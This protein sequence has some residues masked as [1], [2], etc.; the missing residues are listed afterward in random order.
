MAEIK[1][2]KLV[3][4]VASYNVEA[5]QE[6]LANTD[7]LAEGIAETGADIVGL[8][9]I[10]MFLKRSGYKNMA[11]E[12]ARVAGYPHYRFV[13]AIDHQG[14]Q[15]GTAIL[16]KYP[17]EKMEVTNLESTNEKRSLGRFVINVEGERI[18]YL[19]THI[20]YL[21]P[22]IYSHID[23]LAKILEGYE[24]YV[25]TGDFNTCNFKLLEVFHGHRM[26]NNAENEL[27]SFPA[28]KAG[29]DNII[30][31]EDFEYSDPCL[32][33]EGHSDHRMITAVLSKKLS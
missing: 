11:E 24:S 12:I 16:S 22:E 17:I 31:T 15:Y 13:R 8:Q 26:V 32:G 1:N 18:N 10:D 19:N 4:K 25:I 20:S 27:F 9:E 3:F 23:Q 2:G 7:V 29:I 21:E 33:P 6:C 14:G 5:W 28:T 30:M